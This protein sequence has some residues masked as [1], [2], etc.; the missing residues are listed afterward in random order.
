MLLVKLPSSEKVKPSTKASFGYHIVRAKVLGPAL[1]E[2]I[3]FN[4]YIA[5]FG[6]S[7]IYGE[8]DIVVVGCH[9]R[10]FWL[11]MYSGGCGIIHIIR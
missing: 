4:K 11:P 9:R 6:Q 5:A 10:T 8:I 3:L 7:V 1:K 2:L